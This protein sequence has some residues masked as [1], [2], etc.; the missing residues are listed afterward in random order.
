VNRR[1]AAGLAAGAV[2]AQVGPAVTWLEPVRLAGWP[3][4]SGLGRRNHLALTFDDGPSPTSTPLFLGEL[5]RQGWTATF[6]V[7]G[8]QV[9]R[10]PGLVREVIAA[11]HEVGV[12]GMRHRRALGRDPASVLV[13]LRRA[14]DVV[15]D[16]TGATPRWYRPPYGVLTGPAWAAARWLGLRP[17]L[18]SAW[19]R[20]W[21]VSATPQSVVQSLWR[22]VLPGGTALL[23]DTDAYGAPGA[24]RAGLGALPLLA[25]ELA[26]RHVRVGPLADHW[27]GGVR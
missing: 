3:R 27:T 17:V 18:W 22:G 14:R 9:L 19:G 25:E 2:S 6:F 8:E 26:M 21:T 4:L 24:W 7:V 23:H 13:D 1:W 16:L 11:G 10:D 5:D 20:D 15:G 12:H